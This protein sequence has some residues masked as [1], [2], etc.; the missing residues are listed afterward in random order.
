MGRSP[1]VAPCAFVDLSAQVIGDVEIGQRSSVWMN[2]VLRG[3]VNYI[4]I[5]AETNIQDGSVLHGMKGL[6]AVMLGDR[7]TVGHNV[8]LHGCIIED[9]CLIGMGAVV[10]NGARI[11][12]GSII[13][14][15]SVVTEGAQVPPA[16]MFVGAP[17]RFQRHL[18]EA[19]LAVIRRYAANYV[20]YTRQ[21]LQDSKGAGK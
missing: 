3:D 17:A 21:Y 12:R 19:D 1:R 10:L 9:D 13:A 6:Y 20:E 16:S 14:A 5:G 4:R 15:G 11:G 8:T 18:G 7:V 2:A